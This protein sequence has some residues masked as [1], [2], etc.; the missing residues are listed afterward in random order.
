MRFFIFVGRE[1][2]N[3]HNDLSTDRDNYFKCKI[4]MIDFGRE[5]EYPK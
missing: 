1:N 4:C 2:K 5:E 3:P